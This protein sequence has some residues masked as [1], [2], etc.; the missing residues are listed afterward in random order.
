MTDAKQVVAELIEGQ[1]NIFH[2][3]GLCAKH[4]KD[5]GEP[6]V[7]RSLM[8]EVFSATS[9]ADALQIVKRYMGIE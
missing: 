1:A 2:I 7:S 3:L 5:A 4:F 8:E 6:L 9:Y